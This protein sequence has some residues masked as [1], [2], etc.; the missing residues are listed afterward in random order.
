MRICVVC[1][2]SLAGMRSD[3]RYCGPPCRAEASRL[4][5]ILD[6]RESAYQSVHERIK[7]WRVVNGKAE[8][9]R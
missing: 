9:P 5:R 8:V 3:A 2:A 7:A 4:K 1:G 6:G